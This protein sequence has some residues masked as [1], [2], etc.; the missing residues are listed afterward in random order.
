MIIE[1]DEIVKKEIQ[2][3]FPHYTTDGLHFYKFKNEHSCTQV[4][5]SKIIGGFKIE[6]S[7]KFPTGWMLL[8]KITEQEF[9]DKFNETIKILIDGNK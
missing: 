2:I 5:G 8:A 4:V 1:I 9:Y 3:E 6:T 7:V